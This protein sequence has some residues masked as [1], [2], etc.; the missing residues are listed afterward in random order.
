MATAGLV[1]ASAAVAAKAPK[2]KPPGRVADFS[3]SQAG[4]TVAFQWSDA[5]DNG[6]PITSYTVTGMPGPLSC[7]YLAGSQPTDSCTLVLP[8]AK[9]RYSFT[10]K[11]HSAVG[12][13]TVSTKLY[14][15][16]A[17]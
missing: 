17:S 3:L 2:P 1:T 16:A 4:R 12:Q 11:A 7:T 9:V 5:P 6:T 10:I 14:A 13:G 15:S 8:K